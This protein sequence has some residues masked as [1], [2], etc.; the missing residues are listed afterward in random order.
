MAFTATPAAGSGPVQGLQPVTLDRSATCSEMMGTE[1]CHVSSQTA[2]HGSGSAMSLLRHLNAF[3]A[4]HDITTCQK[5]NISNDHCVTVV[6]PDVKLEQHASFIF[7]C[8]VSLDFLV[9]EATLDHARDVNT[10][11]AVSMTH[12]FT[13]REDIS[14]ACCEYDNMDFMDIAAPKPV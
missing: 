6:T 2:H 9:F 13:S 4:A 11:T 14:Q 7:R 5:L 10:Q 1:V 8:T 12:K 3:A